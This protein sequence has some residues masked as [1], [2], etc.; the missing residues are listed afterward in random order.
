MSADGLE[1]AGLGFAY[2]GALEEELRPYRRI[3]ESGPALMAWL[4]TVPR[5]KVNTVGSASS[6]SKWAASA[7]AMPACVVATVVVAS[8]SPRA[9]SA[10]TRPFA[11]KNGWPDFASLAMSPWEP[12]DADWREPALRIITDSICVH[13]IRRVQFETDEHRV[14]R[15]RWVK[16]EA[17]F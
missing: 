16:R 14:T 1:V 10:W 7:V 5:E 6:A 8:D 11:R 13:I 17:D 4:D 3:H 15:H 9:R 12:A 2:D